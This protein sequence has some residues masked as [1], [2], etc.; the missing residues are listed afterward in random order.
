MKSEQLAL[1]SIP[2]T[3]STHI[4][5][6]PIY[7]PYWDTEIIAPEHSNDRWK[8]ADFGEVP[9]KSEADQLTIFYDDS[10][11]PPDPD[12]FNSVEEF[13]EAWSKWQSVREAVTNTTHETA[14]EHIDNNSNDV[15]SI[16]SLLSNTGV[17]E[18]TQQSL[19]VAP[20]HSD[21]SSGEV[22]QITNYLSDTSVREQIELQAPQQVQSGNKPNQ[23]QKCNQWVEVYWVST[24]KKKHWYY[25]YCWMEGRK[26]KRQHI[27][28]TANSKAVMRAELV[29]DAISKGSCPSQIRQ[30]INDNF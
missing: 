2:S 5:S 28:N 4:L 11:E 23:T 13:E 16:T 26:I 14:P 18:Q 12:D 24:G 21:I 15:A 20:E 25:R 1:F 27:G 7:D 8:E 30:L 17:R 22:A 29:K 10:H 9:F 6:K 3:P 19:Q